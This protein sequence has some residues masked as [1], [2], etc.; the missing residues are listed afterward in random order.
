MKLQSHRVPTVVFPNLRMRQ[1]LMHSISG[2][3]FGKETE[4]GRRKIRFM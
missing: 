3:E 1:I 2:R 4:V